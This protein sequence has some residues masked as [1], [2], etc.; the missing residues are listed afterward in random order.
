MKKIVYVPLDELE[1]HI[2]K[3][4]LTEGII[5][6][7]YPIK[8]DFLYHYI[9]LDWMNPMQRSIYMVMNTQTRKYTISSGE[10]SV[11]LLNAP[12]SLYT[13]QRIRV[14][15]KVVRYRRGIAL[16]FKKLL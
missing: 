5:D 11:Y 10:K 13:G 6:V 2:G 1:N 4:V 7:V 15:A 3:V 16:R 12:M 9:F 14:I 8:E